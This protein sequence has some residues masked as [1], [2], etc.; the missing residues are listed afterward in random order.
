MGKLSG[1]DVPLSLQTLLPPHNLWAWTLLE[2]EAKG[3]RVTMYHALAHSLQLDCNIY[4]PESDAGMSLPWLRLT[5]R[6][7]QT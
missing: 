1:T 7:G 3:T 4:L 6:R 2:D 5:S